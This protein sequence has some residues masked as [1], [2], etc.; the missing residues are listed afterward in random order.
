MS[1]NITDI[2]G[3]N[4]LALRGKGTEFNKFSRFFSSKEDALEAVATTDY[5]PTPGQFN[6]VLILG[7]GIAVWSF[8]LEDFVAIQDLVAAGNQASRYIDLDGANDYVEFTNLSGGTEDVLDWTKNWSIGITLVG[9]G[10]TTSDS[11][12]MTLFS[13]GGNAIYLRRG[14]TNW[15]LYIT[16]DGGQFISGA[17]T[18]YA[19]SATSR[20]LLTFNKDTYRLKYYLGEPASGSYAM[21]ANKLVTAAHSGPGQNQVGNKLCIGK[22]VGNSGSYPET[23]WDG[24]INNLIVSNMELVGPQVAEFFQTGEAF[25]EHEYYADLTTYARLGEDTYPAV[26]DTKGNATG[27]LINGAANDFVD[28]PEA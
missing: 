27:V 3:V 19:P 13:N 10:A 5:V 23:A 2:L 9:L 14:G 22:L 15:G 8:D 11:K 21:R 1:Q 18:W 24:G 16:G 20:I 4:T 7:I 26:V 17:N 28:I 12:Y 6:A 25:T